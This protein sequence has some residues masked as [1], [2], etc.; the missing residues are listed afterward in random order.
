M[1][2]VG[3]KRPALAWQDWSGS[4]LLHAALL[5]SVL[6]GLSQS[7]TSLPKVTPLDMSIAWEA[8]RPPEPLAPPPSPPPQQ[9]TLPRVQPA[10]A[11]VP[12][13]APV[14]PSPMLTT[15]LQAADTVVATPVAP[16]KPAAPA[17][18]APAATPAPATPSANTLAAQQARW[19]SV[20]E[21]A[22]L[23]HKHYPL[24]ARRMRQEGVVTI[25]AHFSAHGELL[26][27]VVANGSGFKALD[28]AA[29]QLVRQSA[30]LVRATH[31]PGRVA[32]LRIPIVYELKET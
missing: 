26:Q 11:P 18:A 10:P 16:S 15:P 5:L 30:E 1:T 24:V 31:Q 9:K 21:A 6:W 14:Q 25:E 28:E 13:A 17:A 4:L 27:C 23:K 32:Q 2:A 29:L 19:H 22:L 12:P 20:L 3:I 8:P 7:T